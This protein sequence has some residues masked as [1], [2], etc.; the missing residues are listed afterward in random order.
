[1]Q[2]EHEFVAV[3][4]ILRPQG[5]HGEVIAEILTDFPEKFSERKGLWLAP[6]DGSARYQATLE[7]HWFHKGQVVLK[8]SGVNSISDAELLAGALV[9]IPFGARS[10]LEP[11]AVYVS[12]LVGCRVIDVAGGQRNEIGAVR[13]V[14]RGIGA[15]P[16]LL[17]TSEGKEFEIPFAEQFIVRLDAAA[18]LLEMNL[19]QG[20]LE[21]NAP[22][23]QE[24]KRDQQS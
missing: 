10:E 18:K 22:L 3:A 21:V 23:S 16:L 11:G 6:P 20:L 9:E 15:A 14:Q 4:R 12:D 13:D 1:M 2:A 19:P 17:V 24:E 7:E 8:F 5:R